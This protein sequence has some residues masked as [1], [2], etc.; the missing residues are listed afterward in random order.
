[1]PV[2]TVNADGTPRPTYINLP[3]DGKEEEE[4]TVYNIEKLKADRL[5]KHAY[6]EIDGTY[7]SDKFY[8]HAS[9]TVHVMFSYITMYWP[10]Y[11]CIHVLALY[12]TQINS[13]KKP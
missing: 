8:A 9:L 7:V 12:L 11:V 13:E 10:L 3:Q 4:G 6:D 2:P 5:K 1:V